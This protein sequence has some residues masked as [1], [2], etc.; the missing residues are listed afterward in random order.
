MTDSAMFESEP[1]LEVSLVPG[2][3]TAA[4]IRARNAS[5]PIRGVMRFYLV[6]SG[7]LSASG[8]KSKP[9]E[10]AA[11]RSYF[12]PQIRHL[13]KTH[14]ALSVLSREGARQTGGV[15]HAIVTESGGRQRMMTPRE[16]AREGR[17]YED[18]CGSIPVGDK[19]YL[20]LV[21]ESLHLACELDI[22]FLRQQDP[23]ALVSQGGDLDNRIKLLLDGLKVPSAEE[24]AA[25]PPEGDGLHCLMESDHLVSRLNVDTDRLLF[26]ETDRPNEVHLVIEVTINVLRVAPYNTCL[27]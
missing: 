11:L 18:L 26:A 10:V 5:A 15:V 23:G 2:P 9:Q 12:D 20:P 25:Y 1:R 4:A 21:R 14:N 16:L 24:N 6:Y 27:L 7:P 3:W 19:G 22:L 13:W 17:G 8:N